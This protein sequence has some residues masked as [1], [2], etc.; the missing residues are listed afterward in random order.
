MDRKDE[1]IR[2]IDHNAFCAETDVAYRQQVQR[3]FDVDEHDE[4]DIGGESGEQQNR[5]GYVFELST[6]AMD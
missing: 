2:H 4:Y 3:L 6:K 1:R 5:S